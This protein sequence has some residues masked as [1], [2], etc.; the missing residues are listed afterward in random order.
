MKPRLPNESIIPTKQAAPQSITIEQAMQLANQHQQAGRLQEAEHLLRQ[1]LEHQPQ[2]P[3][4]LHLLGIIAQQCGQPD[5]ALDLIKQAI[6]I[7]GTVALFH[8]NYGEICRQQG[9][10]DESIKHSQRAIKLDPGAAMIHSNLGIAWYDKEEWD[11]AEACQLKAIALDPNLST[12]LNNLGSIC[13]D[14][15]ERDR[16]IEYYQQAIDAD[17]NNPE[18]LNNL[19]TTLTEH[20]RAEASIEPLKKALV[21]NPNYADACCNLGLSM[22]ALE[23]YDEAIGYFQKSLTLRNK[24]VLAHIGLANAYREKNEL[25]AAETETLNALAI[26]P[27]SIEV[28]TCAGDVYSAMGHDVEAREHFEYALQLEP[29]NSHALMGIGHLEMEGGDMENAESHFRQALAVSDDALSA[30]FHLAQVKKAETDDDNI[31]ALLEAYQQV[32]TLSDRKK[33]TL[34]FALGKCFDDMKQPD[35]AFPYFMEGCRL[36]RSNINYDAGSNSAVFDRLIKRVDAD[37]I[38]RLRGHGNDSATPI[39]VLGMPRSGT[40]LTEQIIASHPE[41]YGAGELY[42]LMEIAHQGTAPEQSFEFPDNLENLTPEIA[43]QWADDYVQRLTARAPA[44]RHITDKMPVNFM[45]AGLIHVLLPNARIIHVQRNPIDTCLSCFTRLF[46]HGQDQTYDLAE[47][48]LYYRNYIRTMDH[49]REILPDN[50]FLDLG[51]EELVADNENQA[52]RLIAFC[53]LEWHNACLEF[54]KTK[55]SIRTASITQVRQ[56]IYSSSV[57]RWRH[58]EKHLGPLIEALGDAVQV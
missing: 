37:F 24:Y 21:I 42:D 53:G 29:E 43:G 36:K 26:E 48:G 5:L 10:L 3:F 28:Q 6:D 41:V 57:E 45:A 55:R 47:L 32:D 4:A 17:S 33:I 20:D 9:R 30:R 44:A 1:I 58:Y 2:H 52:R 8:G 25:T 51:Y 34:N 23:R 40:T 39:F 38:E 35:K 7:E 49:W 56:P 16:A 18:P 19:G 27:D 50:A 54:H 14:R 31:S 22:N 13:R 11:R 46:R 15:K 12:A